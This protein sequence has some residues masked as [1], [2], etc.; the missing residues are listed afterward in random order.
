[1]SAKRESEQP[2]F[3][4]NVSR[5]VENLHFFWKVEHDEESTV[6]SDE[7]LVRPVR[8]IE[9]VTLPPLTSC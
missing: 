5:E 7:N 1:M 3:R 4:A 9:F 6:S 8:R 2:S